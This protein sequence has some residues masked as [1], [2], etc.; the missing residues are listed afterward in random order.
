M[1]T[2]TIASP[3]K[4]ILL[5]S[6]H[7]YQTSRNFAGL[8]GCCPDSSCD[9]YHCVLKSEYGGYLRTENYQQAILS[10]SVSRALLLL[11]TFAGV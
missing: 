8:R 11:G 9:S 4:V 1:V 6:L 2:T 7:H 3:R 10:I 5:K